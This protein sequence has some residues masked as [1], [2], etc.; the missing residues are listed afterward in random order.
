L[1]AVVLWTGKPMQVEAACAATGRQIRADLTPDSVV[2]VESETAVI[3]LVNP[4]GPCFK[5][6][7]DNQEARELICSQQNFYTSREVAT[8]W[9]ARHPGGRLVP[10]K[11]FLTWTQRIFAP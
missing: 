2:S 6:F 3:S 9:L 7:R 8:K 4:Q 10:V 1:F 11:E 5:P